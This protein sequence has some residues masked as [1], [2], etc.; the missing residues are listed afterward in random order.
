MRAVRSPLSMLPITRITS[1]TGA[2]TASRVSFT[3]WTIF[4]YS[5]RYFDASARVAS[6]PSTAALLSIWA[7]A[8]MARSDSVA[9]FRAGLISS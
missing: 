2:T 4:R 9:F 1:L 5:P 7:S 6:V 3:P 8:D